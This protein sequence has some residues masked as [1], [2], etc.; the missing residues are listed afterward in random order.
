M[1]LTV[2]TGSLLGGIAGAVFAVPFVAAANSAVQYIAGGAW[3][4]DAPPPAG[5]ARGTAAPARPARRAGTRPEPQDVT[6]VG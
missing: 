6:T 2:A 1:V 4:D 3:K 5:R